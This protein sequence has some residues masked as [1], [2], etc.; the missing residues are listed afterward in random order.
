VSWPLSSPWSSLGE[1]RGDFAGEDRYLDSGRIVA[2]NPK[3]FAAL[4]RLLREK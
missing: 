2:A 1:G 4:L 3:L